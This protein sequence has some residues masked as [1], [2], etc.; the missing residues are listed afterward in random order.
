M[1]DGEGLPVWQGDGGSH[2]SS[3]RPWNMVESSQPVPASQWQDQG[4]RQCHP[5][6]LGNT[7]TQTYIQM[8]MSS[9]M[10]PDMASLLPNAELEPAAFVEPSMNLFS[11]HETRGPLGSNNGFGDSPVNLEASINSWANCSLQPAVFPANLS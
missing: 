8:Q 11:L 6:S 10:L 9:D 5:G 7:N 1:G 3:K 2:W 4:K